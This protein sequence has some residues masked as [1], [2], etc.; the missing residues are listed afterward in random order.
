MPYLT[1]SLYVLDVPTVQTYSYSLEN[2]LRTLLYT[3]NSYQV[4]SRP[5]SSVELGL[6]LT[7]TALNSLVSIPEL[8]T[9]CFHHF[10]ATRLKM[11]YNYHILL[12][13]ITAR[14]AN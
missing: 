4:L 7:P 5:N 6:T 12:L 2:D 9:D 1:I 8:L 11:K 10:V 14:T 13:I 3:T